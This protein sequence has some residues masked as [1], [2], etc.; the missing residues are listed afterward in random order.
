MLRIFPINIDIMSN[1][2]HTRNICTAI[3]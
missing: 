1:S 2:N 3:L